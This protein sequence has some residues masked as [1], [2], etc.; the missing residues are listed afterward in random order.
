MCKKELSPGKIV[1]VVRNKKH[2]YL[3]WR[4]ADEFAWGPLESCD[5]WSYEARKRAENMAKNTGCVLE[6]WLMRDGKF[7]MQIPLDAVC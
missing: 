1:F 6:A 3:Y 2:G 5:A 7:S 4:T